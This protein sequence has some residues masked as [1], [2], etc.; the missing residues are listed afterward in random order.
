MPATLVKIQGNTV[1]KL[2]PSTKAAYSLRKSGY[3]TF[4]QTAT[5]G[6]VNDQVGLHN[7]G[8]ILNSCGAG[9]PEWGLS[10]DSYGSSGYRSK[11]GGVSKRKRLVMNAGGHSDHQLQAHL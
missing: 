6:G 11:S 4:D 1:G 8:T 9:S 7:A 5:M 10:H 3:A 2:L